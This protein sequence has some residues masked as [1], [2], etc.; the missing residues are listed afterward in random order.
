M[1][2][3]ENKKQ[4]Y[5]LIDEYAPGNQYFTDDEDAR[6][7]VANLYALAYPEVADLRPQK[8]TKEYQIVKSDNPGY[9]ENTLPRCK[10][11]R[12]IVGVDEYNNKVGVDYYT[13]GNKIFINNSEDKRV[14]IEYEPFITLIT[15]ET[16]D[17]F[18]LE[19]DEDLQALLPY[20]VA[21]DL[22][23][24][25]PGENYQAFEKEYQRRLQMI[26]GSKFG[27]SA[28]ILEGEI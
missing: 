2:F 5:V 3:L 15:D 18:E 7:K 22:F 28:N 16:D 19:I 8:K 17:D 21:S 23:K 26:R 11:I 9:T 20:H 4:F 1:T 24:T 25:D 14:L 10:L 27:M 13:L 12:S 6:T